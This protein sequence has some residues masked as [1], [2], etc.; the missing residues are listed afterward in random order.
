MAHSCRSWAESR[1]GS[2]SARSPSPPRPAPK[3]GTY[4]LA[5]TLLDSRRYPAFE[6][7]KLYHQRWEIESTYFEIKMMLPAWCCACN[8]PGITQEI[9]ALLT[10]YQVIRIAI[11]DTPSTAPGPTPSGQ[12]PRSKPPATR[13]SA[14]TLIAVEP[15]TAGT[16]GRHS[17]TTCSLPPGPRITPEPSNAPVPLRL[18]PAP[19]PAPYRRPSASTSS[20]PLALH[21]ALKAQ[22]PAGHGRPCGRGDGYLAPSRTQILSCRDDEPGS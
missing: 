8:L 5:T 15:A 12:L 21:P 18:K 16:I 10:V 22:P 17:W 1:P 7:V 11:A 3:T 2:S 4:R 13:S 19:R 6:L 14:A 20:R 9:Y